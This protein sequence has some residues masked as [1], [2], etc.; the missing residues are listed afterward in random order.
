[1][2]RRSA[3][4]AVIVLLAAGVAGPAVATERG[5]QL[6]DCIHMW[7]GDVV[8]NPGDDIVVPVYISNTSG[9]G[10][11]AFEGKICWCAEPAGLLQYESCRPG[12]VIT[13]SGWYLGACGECADNCIT[14]TAA[15]VTP[16]EGEGIFKYLEFHVSANAK[17]CMC[18]SLWFD[19]MRLYDPENPLEVCLEGGEVC[20]DWC[21]V[22]GTITAWY[23]DYDDCGKPY[24]LRYLNDVRVHL[25]QCDEAVATTYTDEGGRFYFDCLPP[26]PDPGTAEI[27]PYCVDVDYC[28]IPRSAITAFDAALILKHLVCW[29]D[30]LCCPIF[31]CGDYVYPQQVAADVNC[32]G[33]IT[34]YDASLIL[35]YAV[36]LIPAL[37]CPDMWL[38]YYALCRNCE[39]F[40]PGGFGIVGVLKGDVS[41]TCYETPALLTTATPE[42]ELGVPQHFGDYAKVAVRVKDA[43]NIS[44]AQFEIDYNSSDFGIMEVRTCGLAGSFLS[45]YNAENGRLLI[46]MASSS[47]F[48]GSGEVAVITLQKKHTPLPLISTR[49]HMTSALLN[50]T[51]PVINGDSRAA[52]ICL[53]SLGPVAPNPFRDAAVITFSAPRS[54]DVS[55]AIYNVNGRLVRTVLSR[56]VEAGSHVI[57]WDGTDDGG[58]SVARGVYFCRMNAGEFS[59]TEKVVVL[60]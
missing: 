4:F 39:H 12:P 8:A 24:Y 53:F 2:L 18:C 6:D 47:S 60:E 54:A 55:V 50:E 9:W 28:D 42:V 22:S 5:E 32:T 27:C 3:F 7:I 35:Q 26:L 23:C 56:R 31:Q 20:V 46:A 11:M 30:L 14:F 17:P 57:E 29:D 34:A 37:P 49:M 58:V 48:S 25:Y 51:A 40:C 59:A 36:G 44:S 45:A 33:V 21:D 16:L 19:Y 10:I 38:W 1:M 41:G 43:H 13:G 15:G 52:E